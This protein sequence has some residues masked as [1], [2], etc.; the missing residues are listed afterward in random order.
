MDITRI[1][2][3]TAIGIVIYSLIFQ[4][5][6]F[7]STLPESSN[8]TLDDNISLSLESGSLIESENTFVDNRNTLSEDMPQLSEEQNKISEV[9]TKSK[10]RSENFLKINTPKLTLEINLLGGDIERVILN[11]FPVS[12]DSQEKIALLDNINTTYFG[13]SGLLGKNLDNSSNGRISY[14]TKK[15]LV[16]LESGS[17]PIRITLDHFSSHG[18][19]IKK[20]FDIDPNSYPIKVSHEIINQSENPHELRPFVQI[21][22]DNSKD[23]SNQSAMGLQAYL[24]F[25][26][27]TAKQKYFKVPF[28][29][30]NDRTDIIE[31]NSEIENVN[32]NA[33]YN[34]GHLALLQ[35]YFTS[36]W[37]PNPNIRHVYSF[38]KNSK[39]ENI[40]SIISPTLIIEAGETRTTSALFYAGPKNQ[41]VLESL[42]PGLDL[43]VDYGWLWFIAQP[44]FLLLKFVHE[45]LGNW[46]LAIIGITII[47]KGIFYPLSAYG[48]Q[49]MAKMRKFGPEIARLKEQYGSDRERFAK[50]QMSLFKREKINPLMGCLPL[51]VQM[52]VFLAL[53]W[54]LMESVE[55]RQ[56]PFFGWITD[57][58]V[59]DSFFV[60]PILMGASMYVQM[61]LNPTPPDP[62][63][64]KLFKYMPIPMTF[65]FLWF[66]AGLT[67]Y[68][69]VNNI[70][71]ILQQWFIMRSIEQSNNSS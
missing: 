21:K 65:F 31:I 39:N 37:I 52:P 49:S 56:A 58:S 15:K 30:L 34:G 54:V 46:G 42:S 57:L 11:E 64:A 3:I 62:L 43:V 44:L 26:I 48:Y 16:S 7:S 28:S 1:S 66:P 63:Q 19:F 2:L 20:H 29:D 53:Y 6:K 8:R 51:F 45:F 14:S 22:R 10:A 33:N 35:H 13:Q 17:E 70:L 38:K 23:P 50:E 40:G 61:S 5:S 32:N 69:V 9:S 67:L 12:I 41:K 47:V 18:L 25:A 27:S 71:S 68:W 60:L 4:W 24:G 55:L 36:A 59:K